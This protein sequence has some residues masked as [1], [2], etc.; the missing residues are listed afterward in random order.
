MKPKTVMGGSRKENNRQA[1]TSR[2]NIRG[3]AIR[4]K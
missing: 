1:I 3:P 2:G 4:R